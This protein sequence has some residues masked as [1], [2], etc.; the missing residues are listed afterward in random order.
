M[1]P[2]AGRSVPTRSEDADIGAP[3]EGAAL[4]PDVVRGALD[5]G[6][7]AEDGR[8]RGADEARAPEG[9]RAGADFRAPAA[10]FRP[11]DDAF[12]PEV[13]FFAGVMRPS[14]SSCRP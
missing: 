6:D 2:A 10:G 5:R 9:F 3:A 12:R 4:E 13:G 14:A 8:G 1:A 11:A 7:G